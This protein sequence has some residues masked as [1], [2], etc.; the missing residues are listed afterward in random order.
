MRL[1]VAIVC[2][3]VVAGCLQ[4]SPQPLRTGERAVWEFPVLESPLEVPNGASLEIRGGVWTPGPVIVEG[5]LTLVDAGIRFTGRPEDARIEVR[6]GHLDLKGGGATQAVQM[7]I[8]SGGTARLSWAILP[9]R[10]ISIDDGGSLLVENSSLDPVGSDV[11]LVVTDANARLVTTTIRSMKLDARSAGSIRL[12]DVGVGLDQL[13]GDGTIELAWWLTLQTVGP[14]GNVVP[15]V[16]VEV[17]PVA[18]PG[19]SMS[20]ATDSSGVAT[21][22]VVGIRR[23]DGVLS[24]V[25]PH[26][27]TGGPSGPPAIFIMNQSQTV[28]IVVV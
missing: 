15:N 6:G 4:P 9:V 10:G 17:A 7:D 8:T 27:A 18:A 2:V 23:A 14:T 24:S 26:R 5:A 11:G 22:E 3:A 28:R 20:A 19:E 16:T 21:T 25:T 13:H 12:V 1:A